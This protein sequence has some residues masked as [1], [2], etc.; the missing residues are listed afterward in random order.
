VQVVLVEAVKAVLIH[1]QHRARQVLQ[2]PVVVVVAVE[3]IYR[4][5]VDMA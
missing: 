3:I 4:V 1:Q 2:L 5:P